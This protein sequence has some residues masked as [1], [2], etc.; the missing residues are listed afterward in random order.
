[1]CNV[2]IDSSPPSSYWFFFFC[3]FFFCFFLLLLSIHIIN[4][5]YHWLWYGNQLG[6]VSLSCF[7]T[8][9]IPLRP[10]RILQD[11]IQKILHA[12]YDCRCIYV[13]VCRVA[14]RGVWIL[15]VGETIRQLHVLLVRG[16]Q[17]TVLALVLV[18]Y[19]HILCVFLLDIHYVC[20]L[21]EAQRGYLLHF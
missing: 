13:L 14:G 3:F 17:Y 12:C 8:S 21:F 1:M 4:H 6:L 5:Y 11:Q 20:I 16:R 15:E 10:L 7:W 9:N 18:L 2:I 19:T